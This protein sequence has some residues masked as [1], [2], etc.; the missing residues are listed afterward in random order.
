MSLIRYNNSKSNSDKRLK[1]INISLYVRYIYYFTNKYFIREILILNL[2]IF[3]NHSWLLFIFVV[4][5][6]HNYRRYFNLKGLLAIFLKL[7]MHY[8]NCLIKS[9]N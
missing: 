7:D 5:H 9:F 2:N 4:T 3:Y 8:L 6:F 1:F